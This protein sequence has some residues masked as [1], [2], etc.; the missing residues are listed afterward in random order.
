M[1][2]SAASNAP[3]VLFIDGLDVIAGKKESSQR[4]MER[5]LVAQ[6]FDSIDFISA[7]G[8]KH[9]AAEREKEK[10]REREKGGES[11]NG[12]TAANGSN[13]AKP[14]DVGGTI[15]KDPALADGSKEGLGAKEAPEQVGFRGVVL[16][17]AT[18]K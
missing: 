5:R 10:D 18:N 15:V 7:L 12:S 14:T 6:L 1:F 16:I 9:T 3:S 2:E 8:G 13:D 17:A 11:S 4:G